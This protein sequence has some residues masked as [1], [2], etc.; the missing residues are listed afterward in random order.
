MKNEC[1][2]VKDILPLYY[3]GMVSEET[4]EFVKEHLTSCEECRKRYTEM[5]SDNS[6]DNLGQKTSV[7]QA[8]PIKKFKRKQLRKKIGLICTAV[9]LTLTALLI[10]PQILPASISYGD[11]EIYSQEDRKAAVDLI[12]D[13]FNSWKGCKLY[14]VYFTSD[15]FCQRELDYCNT[16]A[17]DGVEYTECIVYRTEFRSPIRGGGAWN[18][19]SRYDWSWYLARVGDGPWELLT[20]GAP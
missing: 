3:E 12:L 2:Y 20:W 6:I 15:D 4:A 11:S 14:S 13:S 9:A 5:Q 10:I 1:S 7:D 8:E 19:N 16:L 17:P 18:A